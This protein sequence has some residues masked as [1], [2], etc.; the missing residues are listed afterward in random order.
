MYDCNLNNIISNNETEVVYADG[1]R[2]EGTSSNTNSYFSKTNPS[3]V[4]KH[5]AVTELQVVAI[6]ETF[7]VFSVSFCKTL[8]TLLPWL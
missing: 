3:Y 8:N 6:I 5:V 7:L 4:I 1:G 2:D